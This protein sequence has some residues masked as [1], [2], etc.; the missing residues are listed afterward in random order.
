MSSSSFGSWT[1]VLILV[2]IVILFCFIAVALACSRSLG[3]LSGHPH[4]CQ[5]NFWRRLVN[6]LNI[7][8]SESH[9][10]SASPEVSTTRSAPRLHSQLGERA[11]SENFTICGSSVL[12]SDLCVGKVLQSCNLRSGSRMAMDDFPGPLRIIKSP[13]SASVMR[14]SSPNPCRRFQIPR[15]TSSLG[16]QLPDDSG[17]SASTTPP[18][19]NA[20]SECLQIRRT[21]TVR[22]VVPG[23][24]ILPADHTSP[25]APVRTLYSFFPGCSW[26]PSYDAYN[27]SPSGRAS[28]PRIY[29]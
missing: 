1:T 7:G 22:T 16:I 26:L 17:S 12:F 9:N 21:R 19:M 3:F 29:G 8:R 4:P 2:P 13:P 25:S 18:S 14:A 10:S 28:R 5:W 15:R 24:I 11:G 23:E 6:K 20:S 27:Y